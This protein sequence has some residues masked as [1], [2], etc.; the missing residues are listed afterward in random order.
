MALEFKI[1]DLA[2]SAC[3]TTVTNAVMAIDPVAKVEADPKTKH[4]KIETQQPEATVR[5]AIVA[6]GYTVA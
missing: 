2:C 3:V 1:P 4:A 6:A 5:Q